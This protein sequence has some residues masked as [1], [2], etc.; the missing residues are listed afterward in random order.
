MCH[1]VKR[2]G[3]RVAPIFPDNDRPLPQCA[4]ASEVGEPIPDR[5][6]AQTFCSLLPRS[7]LELTCGPLGFFTGRLYLITAAVHRFLD[8]GVGE[9]GSEP[10]DPLIPNQISN[11]YRYLAAI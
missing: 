7:K 6:G 3:G 9:R 11:I 5:L 8:V 2:S 4:C 10:S 1:S